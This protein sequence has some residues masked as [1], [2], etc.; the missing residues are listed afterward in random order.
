MSS[1]WPS[2]NMKARITRHGSKSTIAC[3]G[4]SLPRRFRLRL[5]L[6]FL[7]KKSWTLL[8]LKSSNCFNKAIQL[9]TWTN[10]KSSSTLFVLIRVFLLVRKR[11][12]GLPLSS[13]LST[14]QVRA[15]RRRNLWSR[16]ITRMHVHGT[17]RRCY[18][19]RRRRIFLSVCRSSAGA[20]RFLTWTRSRWKFFR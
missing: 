4:L 17:P 10:R 18:G 15:G 20:W 19:S 3:H 16:L 5:K 12:M 6:R 11:T 2:W 8:E 7:Q 1:T 13:L 14:L 9:E